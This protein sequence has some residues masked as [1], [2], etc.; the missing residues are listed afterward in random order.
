MAKLHS[1]R[2]M[3]KDKN[4]RVSLLIL[5]NRD[6]FGC[7]WFASRGQGELVTTDFTNVSAEW[8]CAQE[9]VLVAPGGTPHGGLV[10]WLPRDGQR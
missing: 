6:S 8:Q 3:K 7:R 4:V 10:L 9:V 1:Q 2:T 5:F